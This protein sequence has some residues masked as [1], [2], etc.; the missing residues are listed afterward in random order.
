[1]AKRLADNQSGQAKLMRGH[2]EDAK[3]I[4]DSAPVVVWRL[5][6][7][8]REWLAEQVEQNMVPP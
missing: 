6:T 3:K 2:A 5:R 4:F 8:K 7:H 1:M